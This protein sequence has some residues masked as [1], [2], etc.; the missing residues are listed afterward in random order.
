[1][2]K[3]SQAPLRVQLRSKSSGAAAA[4]QSAM[5][6]LDARLAGERSRLYCEAR[7]STAASCI[8]ADGCSWNALS[9]AAMLSPSRP[10]YRQ[11]RA[12]LAGAAAPPPGSAAAAA[13]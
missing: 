2:L 11:A 13:S 9:S 4:T 8:M 7:L 6:R 3:A 12:A 5:R 10:A 1:M